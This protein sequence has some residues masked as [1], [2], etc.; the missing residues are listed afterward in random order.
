MKKAT[1]LFLFVFAS[2]YSFAQQYHME[3]RFVNTAPDSISLDSVAFE[4]TP[5]TY[6]Y[7]VNAGT[8]P[9]SQGT[10]MV[11]TYNLGPDSL[12]LMESGLGVCSGN[13][14]GNTIKFKLGYTTTPFYS[15][16]VDETTQSIDSCST[17]SYKIQGEYIGYTGIIV[18]STSV[19]SAVPRSSLTT[20]VYEGHLTLASSYNEKVSVAV[21]NTNGQSVMP[22][23]DIQLIKGQNNNL[24]FKSLP[25]GMYFITILSANERKVLK[26]AL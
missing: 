11:S 23:Q 8:T 21:L 15:I 24:D 22:V 19:S 17:H 2:C 16:I 18:F 12:I 4:F 26:L 13:G 10:Y 7:Y 3:G 6:A 14:G 1:L 5:T 25:P 20:N 9:S